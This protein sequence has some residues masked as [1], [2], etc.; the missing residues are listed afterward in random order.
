MIDF[1]HRE[2]LKGQ[3]DDFDRYCL[4]NSPKTKYFVV[5]REDP[6]SKVG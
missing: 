6:A 4:I 1:R 3:I 2:M 5:S